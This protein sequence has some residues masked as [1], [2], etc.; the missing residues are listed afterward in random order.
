VKKNLTLK[1][2]K[3]VIIEAKK[4]ASDRGLSLSDLIQNHL[5]QLTT[6]KKEE[7]EITPLVKSLSGI[8]DLGENRYEEKMNH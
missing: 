4:Y 3:S 6:D 1:L 7:F 2:K 8:L 5:L